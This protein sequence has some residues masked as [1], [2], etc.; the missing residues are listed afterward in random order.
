[1]KNRRKKLGMRTI[2]YHYDGKPSINEPD[3]EITHFREMTGILQ[4]SAIG[5]K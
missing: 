3:W 5:I 2:L 4:D 1:M